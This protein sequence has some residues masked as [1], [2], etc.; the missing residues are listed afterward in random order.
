MDQN[1]TSRTHTSQVKHYRWLYLNRASRFVTPGAQR[2]FDRL[3]L[4]DITPDSIEASADLT[5]SPEQDT[6][7]CETAMDQAKVV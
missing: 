2:S 6:S 7:K 1:L 5:A 3:F 4:G